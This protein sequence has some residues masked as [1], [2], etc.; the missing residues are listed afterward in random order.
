MTWE[1][2]YTNEFEE[3]FVALTEGERE[4]LHQGVHL[5]QEQGTNLG[6]PRSSRIESSRHSKMRELRVQ[7]GGRPLRVFYAFDPRRCAILLIGADKT[8][9][10]RFYARMVPLTDRLY[11]EH[12]T[13]LAKEGLI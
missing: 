11:D 9:N 12:L 3:W 8:G 13:T 6:H 1:V 7:H 2:E 10:D 4:S 5:L